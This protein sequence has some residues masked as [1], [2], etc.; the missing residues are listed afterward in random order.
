MK[1]LQI[2]LH[3]FSYF[4]QKLV[5]LHFR[6]RITQQKV[7]TYHFGYHLVKHFQIKK[8]TKRRQ[9]LWKASIRKLF[10][11]KVSRFS[12][13]LHSQLFQV[14]IYILRATMEENSDHNK[15]QPY[16]KNSCNSRSKHG[17]T[18]IQCCQ[19]TWPTYWRF[20]DIQCWH[21]MLKSNVDIRCWHSML[22][23]ML[24]CDKKVARYRNVDMNF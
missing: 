20:V 3:N 17:R 11:H 23:I 22:T 24:T 4:P 18:S 5:I 2:A 15:S 16:D 7:E 14:N 13:K 21:S 1:S 12:V 19:S 9:S 8:F 6:F 10:I